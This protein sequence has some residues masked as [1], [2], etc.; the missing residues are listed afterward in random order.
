MQT[1]RPAQTLTPAELRRAKQI[2]IAVQTLGD[3]LG[4]ILRIGQ[5][6]SSRTVAPHRRISIRQAFQP[7]ERL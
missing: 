3:E 5:S 7:E 1:S 2:V 4:A 6:R